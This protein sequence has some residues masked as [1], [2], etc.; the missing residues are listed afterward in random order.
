M[1]EFVFDAPIRGA[2][3]TVRPIVDGDFDDI[4]AYMGRDDVAEYLLEPAYSIEDSRSSQP[5]YAELVRLAADG[6]LILLAIEFEGRVI[7]HLDLTAASMLDGLVEVGWRMHPDD[8]GKGLAAEAAGLLLDL[9]FGRIGARRAVAH[10]D[11]R[12]TASSRLCERLGMRREAHHVLDMWFKGAWADTF[13]YAI[14]KTEW[15][16]PITGS[17]TAPDG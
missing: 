15:A 10:L 1:R 13:T 7:G 14:L 17:A 11:P 9:A 12:N 6:D 8:H 4:H 5:R 16:H 2:R 3:V